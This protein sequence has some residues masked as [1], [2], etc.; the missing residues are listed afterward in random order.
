[1]SPVTPAWPTRSRPS[2]GSP[3]SALARVRAKALAAV[4]AEAWGEGWAEE[5][6]EAKDEAKDKAKD[7]AKDK[8]KDKDKAADEAAVVWAKVV[9]A[10]V[11]WVPDRSRCAGRETGI[12][13]TAIA[14]A[15]GDTAQSTNV[16]RRFADVLLA[17]DDS[18][19]HV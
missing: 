5:W 6:D 2:R 10:V 8:D 15:K 18:H 4:G 13:R 11:I 7:Q 9:G 14:S 17:E 3:G 12:T 19:A 1:M 16:S